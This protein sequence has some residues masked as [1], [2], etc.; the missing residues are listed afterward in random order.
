[1]D[2]G[3]LHMGFDP[4]DLGLQSLDSGVQLLDRNRVEIL[5]GKLDQWIAGFAREEVFQVHATGR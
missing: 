4:G 3:P 5:L 2:L 1:M